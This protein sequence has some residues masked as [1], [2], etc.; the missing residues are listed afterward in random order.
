MPQLG[1]HGGSRRHSIEE[2]SSENK[3]DPADADNHITADGIAALYSVEFTN[4]D[5]GVISRSTDWLEEIPVF[6]SR[7]QQLG[8]GID[9]QDPCMGSCTW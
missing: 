5:T 4:V 8:L 9:E 3:S 7:V 2:F 1:P 6:R